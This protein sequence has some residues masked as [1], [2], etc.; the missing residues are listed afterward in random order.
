MFCHRSSGIRSNDIEADIET[1]LNNIRELDS[2]IAIATSGIDS[3]DLSIDRMGEISEISTLFGQVKNIHSNI[4]VGKRSKVDSLIAVNNSISTSHV[5]DFMEV[6]VNK[7]YL[8]T[9]GKDSLHF[10]NSQ[11]VNLFNIAKECPQEYGS[12]V[13]RARNLYSF[14]NQEMVFDDSDCHRSSPPLL[15]KQENDV[16]EEVPDIK[17]LLNVRPNPSRDMVE[18]DWSESVNP[19]E[20]ELMFE[21]M[22]MQGRSVWVGKA[23]ISD[24]KLQ[25]DISNQSAGMYILRVFENGQVK[26]I[27]KILVLK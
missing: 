11:R 24:K 6:Y 4:K 8:E 9:V 13:Y 3:N 27:K 5:I 10:S 25:I 18:L 21:L 12:V 1:H 22:S 19:G 2:L 26:D 7:V 16:V 20:G 15:L 23:Q 14:I 17:L